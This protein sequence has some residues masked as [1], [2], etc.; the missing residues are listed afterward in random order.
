LDSV[1]VR[2]PAD[3]LSLLPQHLPDPFTTADLADR[4]GRS[5]HLAQRVAYCLR[6]SGVLQSVGRDGRG[7]LYRLP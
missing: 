3:V 6:E 5:R 1:E 2:S 7:V 4:L